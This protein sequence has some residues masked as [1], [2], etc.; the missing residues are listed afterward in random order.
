MAMTVGLSLPTMA[1]GATGALLRAWCDGI[2]AG[3]YSSISTGERVTFINPEMTVTLA[4]AAART[5]RVTIFG[6]LWVPMLHE[7]AML[8]KQ[9]ATLDLVSNG[10]VVVALGVG[11]RPH[12]Y[13][14]AGMP[15]ARR[16][17]R[18][19][20]MVGEL[21]ALWSGVP[22]FE[23]ADPVGP[24]TTTPG[25]PPILSGAMG[26]KAIARAAKWADG[27]SGFSLGDVGKE[28]A[29]MNALATK[30]WD[31]AG[32]T[33]PPRLINGTF[34]VLGVPEPQAVLQKFATTYLGFFGDELASA[35]AAGCRVSTEDAL[36][37]AISEAEEAGCEEFVI[38][39]GTWDL[40]C[41][42]AITDVVASRA[43]AKG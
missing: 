42:Q 10:R 9:I 29:T 5:E 25:G 15:F 37:E 2:D 4:V 30:A 17:E 33:T 41:L 12:D 27:I 8:A 1:V 13:T 35:L 6:N 31:N 23:G 28:S 21:R 34:C 18:L 19:D 26:P 20:E 3:P 7:S 39:P 16:H 40:G 22:P 36:L 11:G 32:R 43:V 24:A 38:V 14:A